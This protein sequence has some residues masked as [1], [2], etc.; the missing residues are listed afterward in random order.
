VQSGSG[1]GQIEGFRPDARNRALATGSCGEL[2]VAAEQI[3]IVERD[4]DPR[5]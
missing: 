2:A 3:S 1:W 4:L 5:K